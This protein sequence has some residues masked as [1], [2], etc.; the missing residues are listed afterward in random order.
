M[1]DGG[2]NLCC[3]SFHAEARLIEVNKKSRPGKTARIQQ[4]DIGTT[5]FPGTNNSLFFFSEVAGRQPHLL[6]AK[7]KNNCLLKNDCFFS[8]QVMMEE[9]LSS[10]ITTRH[11]VLMITFGE[12]QF[13]D[14]ILRNASSMSPE[15]MAGIW[16]SCNELRRIPSR[17]ESAWRI[18]GTTTCWYPKPTRRCFSH[19]RP[20]TRF[21]T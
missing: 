6:Q 12:R 16:M 18:H 17:W 19:G 20:M 9:W 3:L 1:I 15:V 7:A 14:M 11:F 21:W 2:L 5:F 13:A 8:P 10:T 4:R